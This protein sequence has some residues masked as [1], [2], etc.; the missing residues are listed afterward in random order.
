MLDAN[1]L[2]RNG[3]GALLI[4]SGLL[5]EMIGLYGDAVALKEYL[6]QTRVNIL[7]LV[8]ST[9][10]AADA[11][12]LVNELD[13]A[14]P[15][16][17]IVVISSR[18]RTEYIRRLFKAGARGFIYRKGQ[19]QEAVPMALRMLGR[20]EIY[21]SAEAA[22]LPYLSQ[23]VPTTLDDRDLDVLHLLAKGYKVKE[24]A[25]QMGIDRKIVYNTRDKLRR[26]LQVSNNEQIVPAAI[27]VGLLTPDL[28]QPL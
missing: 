6:V 15:A 11:V 19:I 22:A 3:L 1:I 17:A 13:Q 16:L 23:P 9:I 10:D 20:G 21:L 14:Y 26:A 7:L 2:T 12:R 18:L 4:S 28:I 24:I 8:D 25:Q 5:A 27:A